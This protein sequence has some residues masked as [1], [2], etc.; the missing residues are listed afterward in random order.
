MNARTAARIAA[1]TTKQY[2]A[3]GTVRIVRATWELR[4]I[5]TSPFDRRGDLR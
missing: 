2:G 4:A 5:Q 3:L 1:N